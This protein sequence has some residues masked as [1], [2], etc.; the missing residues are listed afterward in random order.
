MN[1]TISTA[2]TER[3]FSRSRPNCFSLTEIASMEALKLQSPYFLYLTLLESS[4]A[5]GLFRDASLQLHRIEILSL[6]DTLADINFLS[7][8]VFVFM[9][10]AMKP[11]K[12]WFGY[13]PPM[14]L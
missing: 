10:N 14:W 12:A 7:R 6:V 3:E 4:I 9:Q 13:L 5:G 1:Y 2:S 8:S 11:F